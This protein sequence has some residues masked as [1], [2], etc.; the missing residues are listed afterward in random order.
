[1]YGK[2]KKRTDERMEAVRTKLVD[3]IEAAYMAGTTKADIL[4]AIGHLW[5]RQWIDKLLEKS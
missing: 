3:E 1:M 5:T 4:R 2:E